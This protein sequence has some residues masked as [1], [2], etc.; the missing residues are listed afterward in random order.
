MTLFHCFN[1]LG[2]PLEL[3]VQFLEHN[4]EGWDNKEQG[5]RSDSHTDSNT[6]SK[7]TVTVSTCTA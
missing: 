4:K 7:H 5:Q 3:L 6:K 2:L 1:I